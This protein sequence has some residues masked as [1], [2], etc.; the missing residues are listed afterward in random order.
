MKKLIKTVH[1]LRYVRHALLAFACWLSMPASAAMVYDNNFENGLVT[2]WSSADNTIG[3]T[4]A[5]NTDFVR[6]FLGEFGNG[7]VSLSLTGLPE[8]AFT[9]VS[10]SLYLIRSWDGSA[11]TTFNNV[12]LGP[13]TWSL[14]VA[15]GPTLLSDTFSNGNP[16]G[17]TYGGAFSNYT[18]TAWTPCNAYQGYTGPGAHAPMTGANECFSLGYKFNDIPNGTNEPMD[19]VY[20]LSFTFA[21][22]GSSLML[23]FGANGLQGINDESWGLDNVQVAVAPVPVP[24]AVWLFVSGLLG[25]VGMARRKT[26]CVMTIN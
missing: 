16:A 23:N 13:D 24:P 2:G 19:S 26:P 4:Q 21:H 5:P 9:T 8:H 3:I 18:H 14:N 1:E 7:T 6:K 20:E 15:G 10:F 12:P 17:Q 22:T 11:T 25:L